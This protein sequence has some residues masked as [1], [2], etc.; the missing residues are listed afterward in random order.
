MQRSVGIGSGE[1]EAKEHA[2]Y[3]FLLANENLPLLV[4]DSTDR[5]PPASPPAGPSLPINLNDRRDQNAIVGW[6][7]PP[8]DEFSHRKPTGPTVITSRRVNPPNEDGNRVE[9]SVAVQVLEA[10]RNQSEPKV[11]AFLVNPLNEA[12]AVNT[13]ASSL[14]TSHPHFPKV[15]NFSQTSLAACHALIGRWK[16]IQNGPRVTQGL[17]S[18]TNPL[19]SDSSFDENLALRD[20]SGELGLCVSRKVLRALL[21]LT[22]RSSSV[23]ER[24]LIG[25][26]ATIR[27]T[28]DPEPPTKLEDEFEKE[29]DDDDDDDEEEPTF[30]ESLDA[31]LKLTR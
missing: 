5:R 27:S 16:R 2:A 23:L 19:V 14:P 29:E 12:L 8:S 1:R 17:I 28:S 10:L 3:E 21:V 13:L 25:L 26:T 11:P 18:G 6:V 9:R 31:G 7:A 30:E 20:E 4:L 24:V 15:W 22:I